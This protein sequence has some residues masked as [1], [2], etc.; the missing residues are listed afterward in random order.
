MDALEQIKSIDLVAHV[1]SV[2]WQGKKN[3]NIFWFRD[4]TARDTDP[5]LAV[6]EDWSRGW[7]TFSWG[8]YSESKGW[9]I[10]DFAIAFEGCASVGEA[11]KHLASVYNIELW[12]WLKKDFIK[13]PKETEFYT[14]FEKYKLPKSNWA[15]RTWLSWRGVTYDDTEKYWKNLVS[16]VKDL[17]FFEK[18][19]IWKDLYKDIIIFP[20]YG[21]I[22]KTVV[23]AKLR[24]CDGDRFPLKNKSPLKSKTAFGWKSW[25]LFDEINKDQMILCEGEADWV[26]LKMLGFKWVIW[27]LGWVAFWGKLFKS[28][29]KET[30]TIISFYDN[31][32]AWQKA[33]VTLTKS[34]NRPI[35]VVQY[36][37]IE[38][39]EKYDVNDLFKM[40]YK[41]TEFQKFIDEA[42]LINT[43]KEAETIKEFERKVKKEPVEEKED[44]YYFR[45]VVWE[46]TK[47]S[48]ITNFKIKVEDVIV[49][50]E[51]MEE[52]RALGLKLTDGVHE[53]YGEFQ[54]HEFTDAKRFAA[55]VGW[56]KPC[57]S[58][59][60]MWNDQLQALIRYIDSSKVKE[61][62]KLEK[63]WYMQKLNI[64]VFENWVLKDKKF[65]P[66]DIISDKKIADLW[67]YKIQ[68][69]KTIA[70][71]P[72]FQSDMLYKPEVKYKMVDHF[73]YMFT[74]HQG[75]LVI[76][77]LMAALFVPI[78]KK[79]LTPFPI[80]FIT[81]KK[82]YWKTTWLIKALNLYGMDTN[83]DSFE[84]STPLVDQKD[85]YELC[86]FATWK[87]EYKNN[88][89][90]KYKDGYLK[91]IYDRSWVRKWTQSLE[92][93]SF[94]VNTSLILSGEQF[95]TDDAVFS[96]ILPIN[97]NW[98]RTW[99]DLF[100]EIERKS[101]LYGSILREMLEK[102]EITELA[103]E[104]RKILEEIKEL[105][106]NCFA[107]TKRLLNVFSPIMAGYVFFN[108]F[109]L[110]NGGM[111]EDSDTLAEWMEEIIPLIEDKKRRENEEEVIN[112][113]F[114]HIIN[115]MQ[116]P[117]SSIW[118]GGKEIAIVDCNKVFVKYSY[119]YD[120]CRGWSKYDTTTKNSL[121]DNIKTE[122]NVETRDVKY[123][124]ARG[125]KFN[126]NNIPP[127]LADILEYMK[128]QETAF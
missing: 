35:K 104:Y 101:D 125:I 14:D 121:K 53:V 124:W 5:S 81:W 65:I 77:Y 45:S 42:V 102:Y 22:Q 115:M 120:L 1:E 26:I 55:K 126:K 99:K 105:N 91:S 69:D 50:T 67:K 83:P 116:N 59:F 32:K 3:W 8:W 4:P 40:G 6:Y 33:N 47:V 9:S 34:I 46:S 93:R 60:A 123:A 44:G 88:K 122:Y 10:I 80:L 15:F 118:P 58:C 71:S 31:D 85:V 92:V 51:K 89:K 96:R 86:G 107:V 39:V 21:D 87:D 98:N 119:L 24:R 78:L 72:T 27:N 28:L 29:L 79:E 12:E 70:M 66:F 106:S 54:S 37:N 84:T 23:G 48:Q 100:P 114:E 62:V 113:F 56:L 38:W 75:D 127:A 112:S 52:K 95:P 7:Y 16:M 11:I 109:I 90:C 41:E 57:F 25:V 61:T 17:G 18:R 97:I 108:R 13:Q 30:K 68:L 43:E 36:P 82:G 63:R 19:F 117:H 74:G 2:V 64:H 20:M 110:E 94:P 103:E 49:Y 76:G 128:E 111:G 73:R